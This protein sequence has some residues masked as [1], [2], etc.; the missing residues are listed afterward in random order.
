MTEMQITCLGGFQVTVVGTALTAF[1]TD[2]SRALLS[3][4]AIE[5]Y[6]HQRT[7]LAQFLWSGYGEESARNSLRQTLY[8]LRQL[9]Q[10]TEA[11]PGNPLPWLLLTRQ[12]VQFNP[13]VP[14]NV[15]VVTFTQLLAEC[16]A[17]PHRE[18]VTCA[19]CVARLRQAVDLY[20]GDF[21]RGLSVID[22][23]EFEEW[24]RITQEQL[25]IQMID[26]LT[27]LLAAAEAA[28]D[29]EQALSTARRLLTL[30]P[31]HEGAHRQVMRLLAQQGQRSAA[32][33]QYQHCRQV[34]AE[35][36]GVEPDAKTTA[37][38]EQIRSGRFDKATNDK[39]TND[40][41]TVRL[42][43]LPPAFTPHLSPSSPAPLP[44][45]CDWA[46]M[47][48]VDF[49]I[50]R[51]AEV[52]QLLEWLQPQRVPHSGPP[53]AQLISLLGM[54]GIGK[55]TLAATVTKAVAP[56]FAVVIWR[57][58]LNAPP[59]SQLLRNWLQILSR[60]TLIALPESLDEQLRL[61]LTYLQRERCLLVLDNVETIFATD[62]PAHPASSKGHV[63]THGGEAASDE[64]LPSGAS[65]AGV[66]QPG[67]EGYDQLF[68][69]L[70]NSEHQSCLLLTSR[71]QPYALARLGRQAQSATGRVRLLPLSGLDQQAGHLLLESYG[72]QA[73]AADAANLVANYS[74]NPLAL[75][76]VAATIV[77][78]FGG[79][80]AAFQQEEG[81]IFDGIRLIL[82]QQF[83]RLSTVER[84]I[85]VW[86]AI[87]RE[88]I[89]VATLRS[90]FAQPIAAPPLLEALQALQ[91]RSLLE[92]REGGF[93]L[94]NV[95]IEYTTE[96]LVKQVC[97]EIEEL[98]TKNYELHKPAPESK[99]ATSF[100]NRFALLKAQAKQYIRQSQARLLLQPV[101]DHLVATVGRA[102]LVASMPYLLDVLRAAGVQK[103]YAG[104]NLLNLLVQV[105]EELIGYDFSHLPV[106][107]ADLSGLTFVNADFTGADLERSTFT[108]GITVNIVAFQP[109]GELWTAG[110]NNG[111]LGLWRLIERQIT[112]AF[113]C[114][115]KLRGPSVFSP[116]GQF[117]ATG[118]DDYQIKIWSTNNGECWQT[119]TGLSNS[120][121]TMAFS[122]DGAYLA[123]FSADLIVYLWE[124]RTGRC[125]QRLSGYKLGADTLAFSPDGQLLATGS[126][127]GLIQ[128]W[129]TRSQAETGRRVA[130]WQAH[131]EPLGAL[132][133]SPDGRWL[134]SGSHAGE[135]RLW[136]VTPIATEERQQESRHEVG[137][138]PYS[139][140]PICQGHTSIIR[141]LCFLPTGAPTSYL[142]ASA[143]DDRTVR[144]W[145][146][147]GQL[148]YTLL[149]HT[150]VVNSLSASPDG[151][152]LASAGR[153]NQIFLWDIEIGQALYSQQAHRAA[154]QS[155][156][157]SPDGA[158]L[159]SGGAD[160][161]VRLW[162]VAG[163]GMGQLR[164]S[165][166]GHSHFIDSL[167]FSPDGQ[168]IASGDADC[169]IRLWDRTTNRAVQTLREHQGTVRALAFAPTASGVDQNEALL[170]SAG[171]DR[172]IRLW[173]IGAHPRRV[174]RCLQQ[175][176]GHEADIVAL[177]FDQHG[178]RL[179]SGS[180]D[181]TLRIWDVQSGAMLQRLNGHTAPVTAVAI[182]LDGCTLASNSFDLTIRLWDLTTG[183]CLH[184]ERDAHIGPSG[185]VFS[186]DGQYLAYTG[187]D[188]GIYVWAWRT[189]ATTS[190][191][192]PVPLWGH[193]SRISTLRFSPTAPYLA[194]CGIDGWLYL[195]D[196]VNHRCIQVLRPPG[197]YAGMK[198]AGVTGISA[199]QRAALLALGAVEE[200]L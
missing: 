82:D 167:A 90:N 103:G 182:N 78:F 20:Q 199:A 89:T 48:V 68:Q 50:E 106:W 34:L 146:L 51:S 7:K 95:I 101:V 60:Q 39:A 8:Q 112:D 191:L 29:E 143:S 172:I 165:L 32:L 166:R 133:F 86:L 174:A 116:Q 11:P 87:E 84:D 110:I 127:D 194:S 49:F 61:L 5:R 130:V 163:D 118:T 195:W 149:G 185:V 73:S 140:G 183:A 25:H 138:P 151:R 147:T 132:A 35:E 42:E 145:S 197:P 177:A 198:I 169:T 85:L 15:D 54:G 181:G 173:S 44:S 72:V 63:D 97:Q 74:G 38:Y 180:T 16:A 154:L 80:V 76:I 178:R 59:L 10:D 164:H 26:A 161:I 24:R 19:P 170:A 79:D 66:M 67:Y 144:I 81:Q 37:L 100:L 92:K 159:A 41:V 153:D 83:A 113:Q 196:V 142:V 36:L 179:V 9:L 14:I 128:L 111:M 43:A 131:T 62:P 71:E 152:Q 56:S 188:L 168:L 109:T 91:N 123:S 46:E 160:H 158:M 108:A 13:D 2:K 75:Q 93:T 121:H 129:D 155:L 40:K 22:S 122:L 156:A 6:E 186:H 150:N 141:A 189:Y 162:Q 176:M 57:S 120:I 105:G 45:I 193:R 190:P 3:Y 139:P 88:A 17:H 126:G 77:D 119:L 1:Q 4:L 23:D 55:T 187:N 137:A 148:R 27:H 157:F 70:A 28:T 96:Y 69:R 114:G 12:S 134:A 53:P 99:L 136:R 102:Q 52:K 171:A 33:S 94:Q 135:L 117:V 65:R 192:S 47:P 31:W 124:L 107:Q 98:R 64:H 30:E 21:L 58:L 104:G 200:C 175:L 125:I 184:V 115:E 18:L